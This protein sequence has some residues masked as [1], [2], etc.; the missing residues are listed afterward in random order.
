MLEIRHRAVLEPGTTQDAYDRY[1]QERDMLLRDSFY[2]WLVELLHPSPDGL[3]VDISCGQGKLVELATVRGLRAVGVDFSYRGLLKAQAAAPAAAWVAGDG[4]QL[5]IADRTVD[6]VTHI[7]S[8]EHYEHM[9]LGAREIGRILKPAGRACILLPNAF[10]LLGNIR[11]VRRHGEIFD[12]GQPLQRYATRQTWAA[13]LEQGG[14]EIERV[15]PWGEVER[16]RTR[17]DLLRMVCRP[18]K[19][20]RGV[21]AA[22]TPVNLANH[23]VF[24]CRPARGP[25][26]PRHIP[27]LAGQ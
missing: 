25:V 11:Y 24:L 18:Q 12:D 26:A 9:A 7:G 2:L 22:L 23:L 8:L 4:E 13:L 6:Y 21:L 19:I 5:P 17:R 1:F 10:G 16:P 14:L 27:T 3:L 20:V 15:V